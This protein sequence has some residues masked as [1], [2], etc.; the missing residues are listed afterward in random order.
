[1]RNSD[2]RLPYALFHLRGEE[3]WH[4]AEKLRGENRHRLITAKLSNGTNK[5]DAA[6]A[7]LAVM[8]DIVEDYECS[9]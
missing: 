7:I 2:S 8:P 1:M 4:E 3:T 5:G 6:D 9:I